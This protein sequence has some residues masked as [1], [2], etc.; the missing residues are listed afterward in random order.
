[1]HLSLVCGPAALAANSPNSPIYRPI[2]FENRAAV[3]GW[4]NHHPQTQNAI[5]SLAG[6]T[7]RH[8]WELFFQLKFPPANKRFHLLLQQHHPNWF[9]VVTQEQQE[10]EPVTSIIRL[11]L[12]AKQVVLGGHED[13]ITLAF[14]GKKLRANQSLSRLPFDK[15]N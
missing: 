12:L 2:I 8:C 14:S 10:P 15:G 11:L 1:M 13:L 7:E 3:A 5:R 4:I 9:S 6:V